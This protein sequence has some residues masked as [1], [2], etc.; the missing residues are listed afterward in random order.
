MP[1]TVTL[2]KKNAVISNFG[3]AELNEVF[4]INNEAYMLNKNYENIE[5]YHYLLQSDTWEKKLGKKFT[6]IEF[7]NSSF[8]I[9]FDNC[10]FIGQSTSFTNI[11]TLENPVITP[12]SPSSNIWKYDCVKNEFTQC[13]SMPG[14]LRAKAGCFSF[15]DKAY[16]IGGVTVDQNTRKFS[17][18]NDTWIM[19]R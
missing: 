5:I 2:K 9:I 17:P 1:E 7:R 10:A 8:V 13:A 3:C 11:G 16:I 15:A 18:M 12:D 19:S 6:S 4:V 14:E